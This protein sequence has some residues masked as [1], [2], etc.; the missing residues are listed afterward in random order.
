MA[1]R[2]IGSLTISFGLVA[3]PVKLYSAT[4][5][6]RQISFNLLHKTCGSRL[7]QQYFCAK[8]DIPVS[9]DEMVK[10]Y[11][12]AK[13][14][15]VMFTP[16]EL[17][18]LEEAGTHAADIEEFVPISA[19]DPV[20]YDK[21]YYL[22]PDKGGAKPYALFAKA[23]RESKRCALGRWAAR[24]KQYIVMIRP[25]ED[26]LVMQQLMYAGEVRSIRD[27]DI[28]KMDVREGELKLAKQLIE[29]QSSDRFDPSQ[30]T[31]D[32]SSRIEAAIQKKVEGQEI[33]MAET[34]EGGA[35]IIDLME[36]LRASLEKKGGVVA[37]KAAKAESEVETRKPA[38]R[39]PVRGKAAEA[40]PAR[41]RAK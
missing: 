14:Q 25:V 22:A 17:K 41:K 33:T 7:K 18:A 9:R 8:E 6:S 38:K 29:Q 31:D 16:E 13:D 4:E 21:A 26:G 24:G 28:P 3:I 11:E 23:L 15:Y 5:A 37:G 10:G 34:P 36:A 32:V 1:A 19:V 27:I 35:Q 2:S 20:Y 39:A 30:Y 40:T 12:F